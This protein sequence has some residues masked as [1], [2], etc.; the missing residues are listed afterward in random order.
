MKGFGGQDDWL[1]SRAESEEDSKEEEI[2]VFYLNFLC[3]VPCFFPGGQID[4]L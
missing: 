2:L 3:V 1:V 4:R